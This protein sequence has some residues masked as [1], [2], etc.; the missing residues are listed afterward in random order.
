MSGTTKWMNEALKLRVQAL[1]SGNEAL[2]KRLDVVISEAEQPSPEPAAKQQPAVEKLLVKLTRSIFK[3]WYEE[4][5][6]KVADKLCNSWSF[7]VCVALMN[8]CNIQPPPGF[9]MF[10]NDSAFA[11]VSQAIAKDKGRTLVT[12]RQLFEWMSFLKENRPVGK[13]DRFWPET[14]PEELL[15]TFKDMHQENEPSQGLGDAL[16]R[17]LNELKPKDTGYIS[18]VHEGEEEEQEPQKKPATIPAPQQTVKPGKIRFNSVV[19]EWMASG[20]F[21]KRGPSF[22][23]TFI[24][25]LPR[26]SYYVRDKN[27]E[28]RYPTKGGGLW[29]LP[30]DQGILDIM[31]Q[32]ALALHRTM[33][34]NKRKKRKRVAKEPTTKSARHRQEELIIEEEV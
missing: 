1:E 29:F 20:E 3:Y 8:H 24:K 12:P 32:K 10:E 31:K 22:F 7:E 21:G 6:D 25:S 15:L 30:E 18:V 14:G 34:T 9:N 28:R 23:N 27:G 4:D 17:V 5:L 19:R 26:D 13:V 16:L 33:R 11:F 2:K